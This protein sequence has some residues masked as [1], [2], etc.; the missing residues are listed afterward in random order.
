MSAVELLDAAEGRASMARERLVRI[1]KATADLADR[2]KA[3]SADGTRLT[4]SLSIALADAA[5]GDDDAAR[6]SEVLRASVAA[7]A[8]ELESNRAA[9]VE[10]AK[11]RAEAVKALAAADRDV[12]AA[13]A[14]VAA[15]HADRLEAEV[16]EHY[17]RF[18][19]AQLAWVRLCQGAGLNWDGDNYVKHRMNGGEDFFELAHRIGINPETLRPRPPFKAMTAAEI[20]ALA[21]KSEC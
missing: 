14:P 5:M 21:S 8:A 19:E 16:R 15:P 3:V 6:R 7:C 11:R 2:A 1:D 4:E 12:M 20:R 10:I 9:Q 13:L 18:C 17:T